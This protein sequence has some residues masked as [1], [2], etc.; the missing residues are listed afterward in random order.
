MLHLCEYLEMLV[1]GLGDVMAK[2]TDIMNIGKLFLTKKKI[3]VYLYEDI[4]KHE[5]EILEKNNIILIIDINSN[6]KWFKLLTVKGIKYLKCEE[7]TFMFNN[8]DYYFEE[9]F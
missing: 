9:F 6:K 5:C 7:I 4:H 8:G 2:L 1:F 3:L